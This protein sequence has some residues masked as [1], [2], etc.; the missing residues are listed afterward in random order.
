VVI[1]GPLVGKRVAV[2]AG[3]FLIG[4]A[5]DNDFPIRED[6]YVSGHH[7]QIDSGDGGFVIRDVGSRSG[8]WVNGERIDEV[9][10]LKPGDVIKIGKSELEVGA[11]RGA[12]AD[13]VR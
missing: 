9:H 8:T 11:A 1:S 5:S 13:T 10:P 4:A 6:D 12:P 3:K 2:P 7:A